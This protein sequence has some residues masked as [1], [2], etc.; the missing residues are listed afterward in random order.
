MASRVQERTRRH[1]L[2][3][4]RDFVEQH[5]VEQLTMR[6][7]AEEAG[8]SVRTLY[9]HFG[10]K[11]SLLAALIQRSLDS[12]DDAVHHLTS[13]DPIERIWE[14]VSLSLN[15]I[16][17][18]IPKAVVRAVL[19]DDQLLKKIDVQWAGWDLIVG[20]I[21]NATRRGAL[22]GDVDAGELADHAGMVLFHLQRRWT[23]GEIDVEGLLA[24]ALHAFD[25]CLL[26]V[27]RPKARNRILEHMAALRSQRSSLPT[28]VVSS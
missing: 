28:S 16:V 10:D 3:A 5:G 19:M 25:L 9:N 13:V 2:D 18:D 27:A 23:A 20:E 12:V 24:G 22:R 17:V 7:L 1:V 8:V 6:R 15:Q 11:E 21:G 26:A 4:A 14:A